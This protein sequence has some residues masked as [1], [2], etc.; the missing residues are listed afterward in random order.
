MLILPGD[1]E[2]ALTLGTALPPG[3]EELA[4]RLGGEYAFIAR[5]G[6]GLLEPCSPDELDEYIEG[7]EYE[8]R[9]RECDDPELLAEFYGDDS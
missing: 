8:Q 4:N 7:G 5:A 9:L 2:F 6:S 1:P 3:W